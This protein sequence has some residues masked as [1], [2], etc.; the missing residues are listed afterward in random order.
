MAIGYN[1][2]RDSNSVYM[3]GG[4]NH[5]NSRYLF[6]IDSETFQF[7]GNDLQT[8]VEMDGLGS[9]VNSAA[10]G[11]TLY[12][13]T[14]AFGRGVFNSYEMSPENT[15]IMASF[16][17]PYESFNECYASD[18]ENHIFV[19]G[20]KGPANSSEELNYFQI[21][22]ASTNSWKIGPQ[23]NPE[24]RGFNGMA[25]EV[26]TITQRI[27]TFGGY[28][29]KDQNIS[30]KIQSIGLELCIF[31]KTLNVPKRYICIWTEK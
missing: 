13:A 24:Y 11:N 21:Y 29:R 20:G 7:L 10:L 4:S 17:K 9:S 15:E 26:S 28:N 1:P 14:S 22:E 3:L 16:D 18:G 8:D 2:L 12:F 27:Y 5:P 25:C 19:L 30:N 6:Q 31:I 23:L